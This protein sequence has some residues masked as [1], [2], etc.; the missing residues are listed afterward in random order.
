VRTLEGPQHLV[1]DGVF[2]L[3]HRVETRGD[4]QQSAGG[5]GAM[6]HARTQVI[7]I[8]RRADQRGAEQ[9][10]RPGRPRRREQPFHA[11]AAFDAHHAGYLARGQQLLG[12][13]ATFGVYGRERR[14][15]R[16][17]CLAITHANQSERHHGLCLR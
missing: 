4:T 9:F 11:R 12:W 10:R 3:S 17:G 13:P 8:L 16:R 7:G 1:A 2:P 5:G 6:T 14:A 15:H